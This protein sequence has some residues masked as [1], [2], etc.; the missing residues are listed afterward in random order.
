MRIRVEG[1]GPLVLKVPGLISGVELYREEMDLALRAGFR[2]GALDNSG[3]RRD[4]PTPLPESWDGYAAE[5]ADALDRAGA[6]RAVLWGTSFGSSGL[7]GQPPSFALPERVAGHAAVLPAR[8]PHRRP[9]VCGSRCTSWA[10]NRRR[11]AGVRTR[12]GAVPDRLRH[13]EPVGD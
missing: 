9:S 3:D 6:R 7:P 2:I 11:N 8:H 13:D 10:R 1:R 4:D 5:V 12:L